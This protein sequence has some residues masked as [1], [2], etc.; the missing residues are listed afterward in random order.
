MYPPGSYFKT[1]NY[2]GGCVCLIK[3]CA[4]FCFSMENEVNGS[5]RSYPPLDCFDYYLESKKS[6]N[7]MKLFYN[8]DLINISEYYPFLILNCFAKNKNRC[9]VKKV[10]NIVDG[11]CLIT[12]IGLAAAIL[13][14]FTIMSELRNLNGKLIMSY[15]LAVLISHINELTV[16][17]ILNCENCSVEYMRNLSF[18]NF[19]GHMH[20]LFWSNV[21]CFDI[22]LTYG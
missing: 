5:L 21:I 11:I 14:V 15:V 8:V 20:V 16:Y 22:W 7:E 3:V 6:N 12:I 18:L 17:Y 2:I 19:F 4:L 13:I 10:H 9:L 1:K